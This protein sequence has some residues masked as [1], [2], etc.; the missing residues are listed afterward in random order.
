MI[1]SEGQLLTNH[2]SFIILAQNVQSLHGL[3][4]AKMPKN[5]IFQQNVLKFYQIS[6]ICGQQTI[7]PCMMK[8]CI[9]LWYVMCL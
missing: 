8:L 5:A 4:D 7:G 2:N 1:L 9:K 6:E 3:R